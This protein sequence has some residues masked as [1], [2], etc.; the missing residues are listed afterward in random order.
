MHRLLQGRQ[1]KELLDARTTYLVNKGAKSDSWRSHM[2]VIR[3]H[4]GMDRAGTVAADRLERFVAEERVAGKSPATVKNEL[5]E[6]RAAYRLAVKQKRIKP[7]MVPYFPMP[8]VSNTRKGFFEP[9]DFEA[10]VRHLPADYADVAR[11]A[12]AT[13]WRRGEIVSL[14][15]EQIDHTAHEVRLYDSKK[16]EGRTLAL[17]GEAWEVMAR[18]SARPCGAP[19]TCDGNVPHRPPK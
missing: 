10:F 11:F 13:G 15:W 19:P 14:T 2:A 6:L 12:Y 16:G 4:F 7:H 3:Q 18:T 8:T 1:R 5:L 17:D 9:E